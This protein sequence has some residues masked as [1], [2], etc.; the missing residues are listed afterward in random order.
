MY[1]DGLITDSLV[2]KVKHLIFISWP[3][4]L[5][6]VFA[7]VVTNQTRTVDALVDQTKLLSLQAAK[8]TKR[9]V[10][11]WRIIFHSSGIVYCNATSKGKNHFLET[12]T[13]TVDTEHCLFNSHIIYTFALLEYAQCS[14]HKKATANTC[15]DYKLV[16]RKDCFLLLANK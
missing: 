14:G 1:K 4:R 7:V 2:H 15:H 13:T 11:G 16:I 12:L 8:E 3:T 9:R 5:T 6:V 10:T